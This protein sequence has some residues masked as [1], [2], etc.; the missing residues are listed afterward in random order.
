MGLVHILTD[1]QG[2]IKM[3][4]LHYATCILFLGAYKNPAY[5]ILLRFLSLTSEREGCNVCFG[6]MILR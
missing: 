5:P 3:L 1:I 4:K 6:G 2:K